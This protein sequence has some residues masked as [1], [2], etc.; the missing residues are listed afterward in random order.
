MGCRVVDWNTAFSAIATMMNERHPKQTRRP[1]AGE[2][3]KLAIVESWVAPATSARLNTVS[4]MAGSARDA[5]ITSRLEP[6]PPKLVP[7]SIPASARKNRVLPSS[8]TM[9]MRS[10]VQLNCRPVAKVGMSAAARSRRKINERDWN[11]HALSANNP[12]ASAVEDR[13]R[14]EGG[15]HGDNGLHLS[16][17]ADQQRRQQQPNAICVA[18]TSICDQVHSASTRSRMTRDA[19]TSVR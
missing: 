3:M 13:D 12:C 8:A 16:Y 6:M 5:I 1:T 11:N 19:K 9:A 17:K 2:A 15:T 18:C 7:T 10:A 14:A 4:S